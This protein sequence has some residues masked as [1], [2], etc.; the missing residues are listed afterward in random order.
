MDGISNNRK[1]KE[2]NYDCDRLQLF[3]C[4]LFYE[5]SILFLFFMGCKRKSMICVS[6]SVASIL[7][8]NRKEFF[9][10]W[11]TTS[12]RCFLFKVSPLIYWVLLGFTGFLLGFIGFY[13]VLLGC[14][15]ILLGFTWFLL[16]FTWTHLQNIDPLLIESIP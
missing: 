10:Y 3:C 6:N 8:R 2:T 11:S 14:Y 5:P 9:S 12:N 15:W 4:C 7:K 1:K 16:S 13:L